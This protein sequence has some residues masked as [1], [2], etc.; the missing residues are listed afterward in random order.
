MRG[1]KKA[2][3]KSM[4]RTA[5]Y[6]LSDHRRNGDILEEIKVDPI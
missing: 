4:R 2:E 5:R 3:I 6:N 1:L